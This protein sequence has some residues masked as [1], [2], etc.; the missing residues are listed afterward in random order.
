MRALASNSVIWLTCRYNNDSNWVSYSLYYISTERETMIS[1]RLK[2]NKS[3]ATY[4]YLSSQKNPTCSSKVYI[5]CPVMISTNVCY[6]I[7]SVKKP[8]NGQHK[9]ISS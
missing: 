1:K 3:V 9:L 4:Y 7:L 6:H 2:S 5:A 8:F